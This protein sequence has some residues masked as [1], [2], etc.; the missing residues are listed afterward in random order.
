MPAME[1]VYKDYQSQ[2][3]IILAINVTTQDSEQ[4]AIA[5]ANELGLTYPI[6][7]DKKGQAADLYQLRSL[8]TSFFVAPDGTIREVVIG[9]M[10][11][12]LLRIRIEQ[13][14]EEVQ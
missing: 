9:S 1:E 8:P 2:G 3:F 6:L 13:L 5:F 14:L 11:E 7:L 4:N 10:S 12:A